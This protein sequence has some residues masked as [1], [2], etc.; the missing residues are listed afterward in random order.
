MILDT[1]IT[2]IKFACI[3]AVAMGAKIIEKHVTFDTKVMEQT[4]KRLFL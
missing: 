2:L 3:V 4:T 1:L